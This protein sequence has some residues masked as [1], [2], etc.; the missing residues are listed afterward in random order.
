MENIAAR[1]SRGRREMGIIA[2][3]RCLKAR[4]DSCSEFVSSSIFCRR[5][6][7]EPAEIGC[8]KVIAR[9]ARH[10]IRGDKACGRGSKKYGTMYIAA[11]RAMDT[12]PALRARDQIMSNKST[13]NIRLKILNSFPH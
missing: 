3:R 1:V 7:R 5:R 8:M 10:G 11:V 12:E 4:R 2:L 6:S 9:S 13:T